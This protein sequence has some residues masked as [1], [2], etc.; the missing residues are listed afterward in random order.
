M[1]E[2]DREGEQERDRQGEGEGGREGERERDKKYTHKREGIGWRD[3]GLRA[4]PHSFALLLL[5]FAYVRTIINMLCT[6]IS[7]SRWR[8]FVALPRKLK[9]TPVCVLVRAS[10]RVCQAPS[11]AFPMTTPP[12]PRPFS[13][14]SSPSF[15][16]TCTPLPYPLPPAN[17][18]HRAPGLF[19]PS[20]IKRDVGDNWA[21]KL[22]NLKKV[23]MS[24]LGRPVHLPFWRKCTSTYLLV[25][26]NLSLCSSWFT[27]GPPLVH[28]WFTLGSPLVLP[29][30]HPWFTSPSL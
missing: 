29:L 4:N 30:V 18:N 21:L 24:Q 5:S 2:R 8:C 17:N 28:R 15:A 10:L 23:G 6:S 26:M 25:G 12:T 14:D 1:R 19:D 3:E 27:L 7:E 16:L 11:T 9:R 13:W 20:A 22:N